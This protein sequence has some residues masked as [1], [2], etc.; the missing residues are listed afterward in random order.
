ME[1]ISRLEIAAILLIWMSATLA[2][3]ALAIR[4]VT[5]YPFTKKQQTN[6]RVG[7]CISPKYW[8]E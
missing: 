1:D 4:I 6:I 2:I 3:M 5:A 7:G 8:R